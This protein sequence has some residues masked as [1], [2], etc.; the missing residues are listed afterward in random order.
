ML[1]HQ[2]P[3]DALTIVLLMTRFPV[4]PAAPSILYRLIPLA[5]LS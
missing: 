4:E 5:W 3:F 1:M 2:R